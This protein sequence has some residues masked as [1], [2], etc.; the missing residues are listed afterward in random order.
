VD[1]I[2]S[3]GA[4][5]GDGEDGSTVSNEAVVAGSVEVLTNC[6]GLGVITP[7]VAE[8][9]AVLRSATANAAKA[10]RNRI[11]TIRF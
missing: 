1:V 8:L 2:P 6:V 3:T 9:Q 10:A 11:L 4:T 5:D 7:C